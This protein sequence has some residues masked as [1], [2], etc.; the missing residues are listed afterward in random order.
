MKNGKTCTRKYHSHFILSAIMSTLVCSN[1]KRL[2]I[3][4]VGRTACG[5]VKAKRLWE[6][7]LQVIILLKKKRMLSHSFCNRL[8]GNKTSTQ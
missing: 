4:K 8:G 7:F 2:R 1:I 3:L 5:L 6:H